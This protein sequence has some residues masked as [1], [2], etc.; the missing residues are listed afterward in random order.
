MAG[1]YAVDGD[2]ELATDL[3]HRA[4]CG[5]VNSPV[6][7]R[8]TGRRD[9][10]VN[11]LYSAS[12]RRA[13]V[14]DVDGVLELL[15]CIELAAR[16]ADLEHSQVCRL[17]HQGVLIGTHLAVVHH[18]VRGDADAVGDHRGARR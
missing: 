3:C 5:R 16:A 1:R 13:A 8:N 4:R 7:D 12:C 10:I 6:E 15:A 14:V 9:D 11:H 17:S 2:L 18:L